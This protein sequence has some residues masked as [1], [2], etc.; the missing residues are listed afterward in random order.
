MNNIW[1]ACMWLGVSLAVIMGVIITKEP[2]CLFALWL[3]TMVS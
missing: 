2:W 1:K 3:P